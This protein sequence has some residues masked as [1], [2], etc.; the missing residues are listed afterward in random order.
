MLVATGADAQTP[1]AL[2]GEVRSAEGV[3]EGVL[4]SAKKDG[5]NITVTVV[6]DAAGN[7]AFPAGRLEPGEYRLS[8]RAVGYVLES[9]KSASV[10]SAGA[11]TL[12][13]RLGKARNIETQLSNAEWI[14]SIPGEDQ[15]KAFLTECTG[16]HTLQR[17]MASTYAADDWPAIFQRMGLYSPGSTPLHPQPLLPGPRGERP[18]VRGEMVKV[19]AE[20]LANANLSGSP[21]RGYSLKTLP[22]PSGRATRVIYTEYDLPRKDAQPHDVIL[23]AEGIAWY[24]DFA[25]QFIGSLDPATG[26]AIDYV[27]PT[28][29]PEAPK[30]SLQIDSD[31]DGNLWVS[32]MYQAGLTK[33]DRKK[34]EA[35]AYPIPAAWQTGSTQQSMVAPIASNVDG[36]VWTNNQETHSIYRLDVKTGLYE[37]L[38]EPT[39]AGGK[40]IGAYGI[41]VDRDNNVY[42]LEFSNT[43]IGRI[44]RKSKVTTIY[45]TPTE[46]ARPR[47]GRVDDQ[48]RLWFGEY[49]GNAIGMFD[50]VTQA[51]REWKLPMP[52]NNPYDVAYARGEAWTGSMSNDHVTRLF[53]ATGEFVQYLL[54]RPTNIRRVFLDD[55]SAR[56]VLW[57]GSNHGA[58]VIKVEP[59]D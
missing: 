29:K 23:D 14:M 53:P 37:D 28:L 46:R 32:M 11:A 42:L 3:L 52:W 40:T 33:F 24:S 19:A 36:K 45:P 5:S 56:P 39:D 7:F 21:V 6:S 43:R 4:V 20:L 16:C 54:P 8:I 51:I 30:G 59:L 48:N 47:R 55:R 9:P 13:L 1:A 17:V 31:P 49:G 26:K 50:P 10:G 18:R 44:D 2:G 38:G 41:P 34:K 27:I 57:I 12:A 58:S 22:R 25:A 15:Q 35:T